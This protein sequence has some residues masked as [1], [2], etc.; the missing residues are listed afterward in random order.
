MPIAKPAALANQNC[1]QVPYSERTQ[2]KAADGRPNAAGVVFQPE[3][4]VFKVWDNLH[5]G[6]RVA[7]YF[8]Y[9][10]V[11]DKWKFV[12]SPVDGHGTSV[13]RNLD[14][15][16]KHICFGV[17]THGPDSPIVRYATRP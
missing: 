3:G 1:S 10:G 4:D 6:K 16:Y 7:A 11:A 14:E 9:A 13:I 17:W 8:N 5:D 15:R 12:L 2:A